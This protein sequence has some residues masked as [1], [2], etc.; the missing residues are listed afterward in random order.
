[1]N[2]HKRSTLRA[3]ALAGML[4]VALFLSACTLKFQWPIQVVAETTPV[5]ATVATP[6][7]NPTA[8]PQPMTTNVAPAPVAGSLNYDRGDPDCGNAT[9]KPG[10]PLASGQEAYV[11]YFLCQAIDTGTEKAMFDAVG[12]IQAMSSAISATTWTGGDSVTIP[13][14][15]AAL[16]WCA[17]TTGLATPNDIAFPLGQEKSTVLEYDSPNGLGNVF[18]LPPIG[19]GTTGRT[20]SGCSSPEGFWAV[21]VH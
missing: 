16:V 21:A 17:N 8:G 9:N 3:S 12:K 14:N 4:I 10:D 15:Q 13:E 11:A 5:P 2:A 19:G 6:P 1:M 20:F 7:V 18:V